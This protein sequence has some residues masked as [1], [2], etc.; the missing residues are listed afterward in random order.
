MSLSQEFISLDVR[1]GGVQAAG[2]G[3]TRWHPTRASRSEP[4][5]PQSPTPPWKEPR[6]LEDP[7]ALG[8]YTHGACAKVSSLED[9]PSPRPLGLGGADVRDFGVKASAV[10]SS[11]DV[12]IVPDKDSSSS[13]GFSEGACVA[14]AILIPP[15]MGHM[16]TQSESYVTYP[17]VIDLDGELEAMD[18][19][20][21]TTAHRAVNSSCN[22][23]SNSPEKDTPLQLT[24][25]N[26][27][28]LSNDPISTD[29][30]NN[31]PLQQKSANI[32]LLKNNSNSN[33]VNRNNNVFASQSD[34]CLDQLEAGAVRATSSNSS[35]SMN[36]R[37]VLFN[38]IRDGDALSVQSSAPDLTNTSLTY[39]SAGDED[40]LS[41]TS[42]VDSADEYQQDLSSLSPSSDRDSDSPTVDVPDNVRLTESPDAK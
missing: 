7:A 31:T 28:L 21:M 33:N 16:H 13:S 8:D 9:V 5:R 41:F 36:Q 38:E 20:H 27:D 15:N 30:K 40:T 35:G 22:S 26:T 17:T 37:V 39:H 11:P 25:A 18:S 34:P 42:V 23:N 19:G 32:D 14:D 29:T 1:P 6:V 10:L 4:A 12:A 3:D 2:G 24:S